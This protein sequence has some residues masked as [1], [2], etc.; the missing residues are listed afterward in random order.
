MSTSFKNIRIVL[1]RPSR[2]GNIGAAARAI[3]NMGFRN[4]VLIDPIEPLHPNA[5]EMAYGAKDVLEGAK[6]YKTLRQAV[7]RCRY[8]VGTT[9]RVHK[10]YGIPAP[11]AKISADFLRRARLHSV[12]ILFGPESSGLTNEEVALCQTLVT[13][14]TGTEHTSL[15]LAQ[16]VMAVA[17]ELRRTALEENGAPPGPPKFPPAPIDQREYFY[18]E[19]KELLRQIG[20]MKGTQGRHILTDLRRIFNRADTDERE[21]RILRGIIHQVRWSLSQKDR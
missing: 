16:A 15:N 6:V 21:M 5:Y 7:G 14:P 11:L 1:V 9:A 8:V 3:K 18:G 19:L 13:I 12:A 4:L 17:Y 2:P 10:G 20:F